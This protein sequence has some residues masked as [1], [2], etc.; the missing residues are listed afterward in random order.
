[1]PNGAAVPT[2]LQ[3]SR[4]DRRDATPS[5]VRDARQRFVQ[6]TVLCL[7]VLGAAAAAMIGALHWLDPVPRLP[8]R[9]APLSLAIILLALAFRQW[10]HPER[11]ASHL[12]VGWATVLVAVALPVWL[13]IRLA[14]Q[15]GDRLV[16]L[17]PPV[18]PVFLPSLMVMALFARPRQALWT[19]LAAWLLIA[20][21][22]LGYL[23]A[24]PDEIWTPRGLDL[25]LAFGPL[26]LFVPLLLPL[27]R[28]VEQRFHDMHAEG[29]RLQ[30]LAE[31]DVLIGLYNRR[32]GERF[33]NTLL[34]HSRA[35][36]ALILF[37]IDHFKRIND[38]HGHPAGDA[39]LIEVGKR[40]AAELSASDIFARWGGEEFLVVLPG[41]PGRAADDV[42]ERLRAAI[43]AR[44][45]EPV[46]S[47]SASFGVTRVRVDDTLAEV[48]QRADDALYQAKAAGRNCVVAL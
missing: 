35:D 14:L 15:T 26:A 13:F 16:D 42:A 18:A 31:R 41:T 21:P 45:I 11:M 32:A 17:L 29:E 30:A 37:D 3:P 23:L 28:G 8:N 27:L 5:P 19:T 40:C 44:P 25:V 10:R 47:V 20:S 9:I 38:G 7:F 12:W 22:V 48:L 34:A 36:A 2:N 4:H 1:M 24:H 6:R 46:G 43:H 39:V 33:L